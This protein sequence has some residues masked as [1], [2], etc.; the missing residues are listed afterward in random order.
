MPEI[1]P[2]NLSAQLD[3]RGRGNP[4]STHPRSFIANCFPGLEFDFRNVWKRFLVG[5]ELHESDNLVVGVE[6]GSLAA[7]QGVAVG[8]GLIS[9]DGRAVETVV[10]G[11]PQVGE[12][13]VALRANNLE[14]TNSIA[15]VVAKAG[16]KVQCRL[17]RPPNSVFEVTL[18]VRNLFEG[19]ALAQGAAQPG[20]LTQGLCSPWQADYREC[21]CYYWAASRPDFVNVEVDQNQQATGHNWM[22]KNR[23]PTTPKVYTPDI[24]GDPNQV[25]YEDLYRDWEGALRFIIGGRDEQ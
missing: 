3:Y 2:K 18:E 13:D 12:P 11:P 14:W 21:G 7:Q 22:L 8:D 19:V 10:S 4:P 17:R 16:Q 5:I 6:P 25:G 9:I 20:A 24:P 1:K 23:Q 15:D